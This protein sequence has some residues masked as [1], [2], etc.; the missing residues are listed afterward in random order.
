M[1]G[2]VLSFVSNIEIEAAALGKWVP[3]SS[4]SYYAGLGFVW[5]SWSRAD[6]SELPQR[7]L[8]GELPPKPDQTEKAWL[9]LYLT[10][11][12]N[13]LWT[14]FAPQRTDSWCWCRR[15]PADLFQHH[16][17]LHILT[18]ITQSVPL[19]L[20]R[21][22]WRTGHSQTLIQCLPTAEAKGR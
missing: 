15:Q 22:C 11:V 8:R 16:A 14:E 9:C 5:S 19:A 7:G 13:R 3:V 10:T 4:N 6:Y 12:S 18:A 21:H 2:L 17:V 20:V 1:R